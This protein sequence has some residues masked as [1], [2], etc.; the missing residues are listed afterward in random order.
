MQP[1]CCDKSISVTIAACEQAL[2]QNS[3][4]NA[5]TVG[6]CDRTLSR[7][8]FLV[9]FRFRISFGVNEAENDT[10]KRIKIKV[11]SNT[12]A[13]YVIF[14]VNVISEVMTLCS[15]NYHKTAKDFP[16][17]YVPPEVINKL[18]LT[19]QQKSLIVQNE[20]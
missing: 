1:I 14:N 19:S 5:N 2:K 10:K 8:R 3:K 11:A 20:Y 4:K 15:S 16:E 6:T 17:K 18:T 7:F 13:G 12:T 9:W